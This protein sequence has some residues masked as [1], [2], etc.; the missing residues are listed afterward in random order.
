MRVATEGLR[1]KSRG[2]PYEVALYLSYLHIE[3]DDEITRKS[4]RISNTLSASLASKVK[5]TSRLGFIC[6]EMSQLLRF[7]T[8]MYG[9]DRMCDK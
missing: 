2:S 4:R 7:V 6:S 3:F 1:L 9:N 8:Q 5:L